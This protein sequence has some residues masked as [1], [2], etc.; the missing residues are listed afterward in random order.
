MKKSRRQAKRYRLFARPHVLIFWKTAN[1]RNSWGRWNLWLIYM[2]P[3]EVIRIWEDWS[4]LIKLQVACI[5]ARTCNVVHVGLL[6]KNAP[7]QNEA[8]LRPKSEN[9]L[10]RQSAYSDNTRDCATFALYKV[11]R[12]KNKNSATV[13]CWLIIHNTQAQWCQLHQIHRL[14]STT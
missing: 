11:T 8:H 5:K 13:T 10:Y 12:L 3:F 6:K 4:V 1:G 2:G 14:K 9:G 7:R